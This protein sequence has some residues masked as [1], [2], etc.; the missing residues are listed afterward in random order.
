MNME[1]VAWIVLGWFVIALLVSIVLGGFLSQSKATRD[2]VDF[3]SAAAKS[4]VLRFMRIPAARSVAAR[5]IQTAPRS[6]KQQVHRQV[7]GLAP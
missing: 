4:K 1:M 7:D 3:A 6:I 5:N 2:E